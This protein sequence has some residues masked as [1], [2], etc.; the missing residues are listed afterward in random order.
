[1]SG[2]AAVLG[3]G[4]IAIDPEELSPILSI[5]QLRGPDGTNHMISGPAAL[6]CT[7]LDTLPED[8]RQPVRLGRIAVVADARLDNRPFLCDALR[9]QPNAS[10]VE[11]IAAAILKWESNAPEHLEGDF[12]VI[13]WDGESLL[14]FRD[15]YGVKPLFYGCLPGRLLV[16]SEIGALIAHP[17]MPCD[18][19]QQYFLEFLAARMPPTNRTPYRNI[20]RLMPGEAMTVSRANAIALHTYY[21]LELHVSPAPLEEVAERTRFLLEDAVKARLRSNGP[22]VCDVSGGM[23]STAIYATARAIGFTPHARSIVSDR[24][25]HIDER[26]YSRELIGKAP[27]AWICLEEHPPLTDICDVSARFDEPVQDV[28]LGHLRLALDSAG[29]TGCRVALSGHGGDAL[30][31]GGFDSIRN[32]IY[33]GRFWTAYREARCWADHRDRSLLYVLRWALRRSYI[34]PSRLPWATSDVVRR[35]STAA[36]R[37]RRM[38]LRHEHGSDSM[39]AFLLSVQSGLRQK[40]IGAMETRYPYLHRPLVEF[41]LST[42]NDLKIRG[43]IGK[44]VMR[45]AMR[46]RLPES[47]LERTDKTPFDL[48]YAWGFQSQ[49]PTVELLC[50][51]SVLVEWGLLNPIGLLQLTAEVR[52]GKTARLVEAMYV[53]AIEAWLQNRHPQKFGAIRTSTS[54]AGRLN[55]SRP[56]EVGRR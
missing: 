2:V 35:A 13:S 37:V 10:D 40:P 28:L 43:A 8:G 47:I 50:K 49:W 25:P 36:R 23:D 34:L 29:P 39:D 53:L 14:A 42:P 51:S 12:A 54:A 22:T 16:A 26:G 55:D 21:E 48:L 20:N 38:L 31:T 45:H 27:W 19:D 33:R 56:S 32:A 1:V 11:L 5:L 41:A 44:R 46:R 17:L 7:R 9:L 24:W 52:D 4:G 6:G 3:L 30:M 15:R 18:L